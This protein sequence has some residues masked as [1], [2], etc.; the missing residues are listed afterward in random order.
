MTHPSSSSD[1]STQAQFLLKK[2]VAAL[3]L[4]DRRTAALYASQ[5]VQL[6]PGLEEGWLILAAIAPPDASLE[7]LKKALNINPTSQRARAGMRWA[8]QRQREQRRQQYMRPPLSSISDTTRLKVVHPIIPTAVAD[9]APILVRARPAVV[10]RVVKKKAPVRAVAGRAR[11]GWLALIPLSM[12][13][14]IVALGALLWLGFPSGW[15]VFAGGASLPR[16]VGA[17]FKPSLTPTFTASPTHTVT[18]SPTSTPTFT[19]TP[20]DTPTPV[21]TA[22][23]TPV[24]TLVPTDPP[25]PVVEENNDTDYTGGSDERWID[26]NLS[27]QTLYA[28]E[29]GEVVNSFIVSTGTWEHPT[30]TGQ[31]NIYVKYTYAD[32]AGPGYYLADVPYVMYFYKG[33]GLHGTYWHSN[34]GTP[35]SHGCV[36]LPTD[37]AGWL[38]DWA[39]IGT[40]VNVHY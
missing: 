16:P 33:Y 12:L 39:S 37:A 36:N 8:L 19:P 6:N 32:M 5:A 2:A 27:N 24:P 17:L 30:V 26:V 25:P 31:F 13:V 22:T 4:K 7:Y 1:P 10:R 29:G 18:A 40:L 34:F 9:T 14:V 38:F 21:P 20:T 35:M 23:P 28:Y 11:S 15:T 3:R